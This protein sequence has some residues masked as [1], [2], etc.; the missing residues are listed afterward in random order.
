MDSGDNR[1]K[2]IK[3]HRRSE[4]KLLLSLFLKMNNFVCMSEREFACLFVCGFVF[5][6]FAFFPKM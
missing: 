4:S 6:F 1:F 3:E 2:H 5:C